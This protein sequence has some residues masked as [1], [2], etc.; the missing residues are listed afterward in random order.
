[1]GDEFRKYIRGEVLSL[2]GYRSPTQSARVK[3]N[4][5]ESPFDVPDEIKQSLSEALRAMDW[6]RY[7]EASSSS[8]RHALAAHTGWDAEGLIVGNGSNELIQWLMIAVVPAGS[9][10]VI[11][12]PT[13][14]LYRSQ[15]VLRSA[16]PVEVGV[17]GPGSFDVETLVGKITAIDPRAV[18]V[19]TP[20]NPTGSALTPEELQQV[21][22][23]T[24]GLVICDE[25][26]AEF[27]EC[28]LLGVLKQCENL[29]LLRTF[30]K[31]FG[32]AGFRVG[33]AMGAPALVRELNKVRLPY[34]LNL[35]SALI[36]ER[37]LASIEHTQNALQAILTERSRLAEGLSLMPGIV[38]HPTQANFILCTIESVTPGSL[39]TELESAGV[40]VRD[41]SAYPGLH[42]CIRV[43]VGKPD[44][45]DA[46]L[47]AL[48]G[49]MKRAK[50]WL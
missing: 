49:A 28:D 8:L 6:N 33:Y 50:E 43:T 32:L 31:A 11:A 18:V 4:Q 47:D 10:V 40:L 42:T 20:N 12:G 13:F 48:P 36:A 39:V 44:E 5:N 34:N 15:V 3:L 17:A 19:C 46:L 25:A 27:G 45:T 2:R 21:C 30:S 24:R 22:K 29:V 37:L 14:S 9:Q 23:S 1:M 7:P 16:I 35:A 26:Y 38:P 41:V